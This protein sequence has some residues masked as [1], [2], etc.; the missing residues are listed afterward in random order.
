MM[1]G[2]AADHGSFDDLVSY[3]RTLTILGKLIVSVSAAAP[4]VSPSCFTDE[5]LFTVL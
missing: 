2:L 3:F 4:S 5:V 1:P